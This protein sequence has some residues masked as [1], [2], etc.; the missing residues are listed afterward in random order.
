V[1]FESRA[2]GDFTVIQGNIDGNLSADFR[3]EVEG[4]HAVSSANVVG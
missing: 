3:I 1:S 4:H 2:D